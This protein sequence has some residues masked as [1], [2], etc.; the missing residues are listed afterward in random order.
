MQL[1]TVSRIL[2][3]FFMCSPIILT[4]TFRYGI[5]T[6]YFSYEMIFNLLHKT[7]FA[8]Y[9][10][11]HNLN[12]GAYYV[13]PGYY[14]LNRFLC[15]SFL[16]LQFVCSLLILGFVYY[17]SIGIEPKI[18]M[19]WVIFIYYTTQFISSI[20]IIRFAIASTIVFFGIKYLL[21]KK[22]IAWCLCI[23]LAYCFHKTSIICAPLYLLVD[24]RNK[25][26]SKIRNF[27]WV[28]FVLSFPIMLNVLFTIVT[29]MSM[30]SRYFSTAKYMLGAFSFKPM[31][32][33]HIVPIMLPLVLV[34]KQFILQDKKASVLFR[35]LLLEIPM[36]EL[37]AVNTWCSR[38]ARFPQM[39]QIVFIPY[40]LGTI[41][42]AKLKIF[43]KIY[44]IVWYV[45]YFIYY[46]VVNDAG[47]SLPYRSILFM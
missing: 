3:F 40:V 18:S 47:D 8:D 39:V 10:R 5:G 13:E 20:N 9:L 17:G 23:G 33:F 19:A 41:K 2:L 38:L 7:R 27:M 25:T 24:I 6:D 43:L 45:F 21:E 44:Y 22:L 4:Y 34:R 28:A 37:G 12:W 11:L 35:I 1:F 30:F 29:N 15:F 31:F 36:R 14:V 16:S 32:M 46:A 26:I 42:N